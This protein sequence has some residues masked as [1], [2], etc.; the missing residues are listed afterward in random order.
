MKIAKADKAGNHKTPA[1][2]KRKYKLVFPI[3]N[4]ATAFS[5]SYLIESF[6]IYPAM[7]RRIID[8]LYALDSDAA[9]PVSAHKRLFGQ[10]Y[11]NAKIYYTAAPIWMQKTGHFIK[12]IGAEIKSDTP[13]KPMLVDK[14][15]FENIW[16]NRKTAKDSLLILKYDGFIKKMG[17]EKFDYS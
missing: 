14:N 1:G 16:K 9:I 13:E 2:I 8:S 10:I 7:E 15:I 17:F 6:E 11:P 5:G 12:T 4:M 3:T